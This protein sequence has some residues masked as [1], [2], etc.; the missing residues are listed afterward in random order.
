MLRH[1]GDIWALRFLLSILVKF[2]G[3]A[4]I[5]RPD[6]P[7]Y[8]SS[9][10]V[11]LLVSPSYAPHSMKNPFFCNHFIHV[12]SNN[13]FLFIRACHL[14]RENS[15]FQFFRNILQLNNV[16]KKCSMFSVLFKILDLENSFSRF[17]SFFYK[18]SRKK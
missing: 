11:L 6:Q 5:K 17:F 14:K 9:T 8:L 7:R 1:V 18:L 12:K 15:S 10:S 2:I 3:S 16:G 4:S 13:F